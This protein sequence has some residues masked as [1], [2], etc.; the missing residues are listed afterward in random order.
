MNNSNA[1]VATLYP[2]ASE[3]ADSADQCLETALRT[4]RNIAAHLDEASCPEAGD[5]DTRTAIRRWLPKLADA[6][7]LV[8]CARDSLKPIAAPVRQARRRNRSEPRG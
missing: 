2:Q 8:Q 1:T 5:E 6:R 4:L 7:V 3:A